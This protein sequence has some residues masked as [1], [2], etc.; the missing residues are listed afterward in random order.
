MGFQSLAAAVNLAQGAEPVGDKKYKAFISYSHADEAWG[1]W[2][3][4]SLER[5]R[6]PGSLAVAL[7]AKGG[8]ARL[9]PVFRDREDLPVAGNLNSAIQAALADSEFQIVLCSPSSAKSRWVNE[10]IKLFHKLHGPG[11][12]FALIVGGEPNATATPGRES[13]ECFPP[14]LRFQIDGDGNLLDAPAEPLAADAREAGDGKR[15]ALLKVAAGM[16]GVGLDD[17]V[18]RDATRRARQAWTITG[19]SLAGTAMTLALAVF[20]IA[21]SNEAT[22]MRG[23]AENLIEFMLTD[24]KDKLEPVG[25]LDVLESVV[26]RAMDYYADQDPKSLDDN[27]L[28]RRAKAMMQLGTIEFRRNNL[29]AAKIAYE[30]AE[31]A[32]AELLRRS[33]DHPDRIFDHAQNVFYVGEVAVRRY[34]QEKGEAKFQE[35]LRLARLLIE[36]DGDNPRS[37]LE[38]AYATSNIGSTKFDEGRYGEAIPYFEESIAARK[39]LFDANPD[40]TKLLLAYA[41]AI[42]WQGYAE[43]ERG[44]YQAAIDLFRKQLAAYGPLADTRSENFSALDA[45]VTVQRRIAEAHLLLGEITEA[46]AAIESAQKTAGRLIERDPHNANWS[47]NACHIQRTKSLLLALAGDR[48]AAIEAADRSVDIVIAV[49][50]MDA[51]QGFYSALGQS[52]AWRLD[53]FGDHGAP[54]DADRL[55]ELIT[56]AVAKEVGAN[57]RFI[58]VAS[59]SLANYELRMGRPERADAVRAR[60]IKSLEPVTAMISAAARIYLAALYLDAGLR[61][62]AAPIISELE[63]LEVKH[64]DFL[65][66]RENY[67]KFAEK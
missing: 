49:L 39:A 25:R 56:S 23:K 34:D 54:S 59:L 3:Q 51:P 32:T 41:Y 21:K 48:T 10:E 17:L 66:L 6:A 16:L 2:L 43:L 18:R 20:A 46:S 26:A 58:G 64:P 57:A 8:A 27:A 22:L 31:A 52:L 29:D 45:V 9:A 53:L 61:D 14:A 37:R 7:E 11:R 5:F 62:E 24:L 4:R 36:V 55:D 65:A 1:G 50:T 44:H 15:Y 33:P 19:A 12:V 13:E 60:A 28:A 38:L 40:D 42:S 47:L 67:L 30:T 63:G 35:Y